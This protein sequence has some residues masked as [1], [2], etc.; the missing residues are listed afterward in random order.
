M[1]SRGTVV[2]RLQ[3]ATG[4]ARCFG[5]RAY[6]SVHLAV[7]EC[8]CVTVGAANL[9]IFCFDAKLSAGANV[10]DMTLLDR[11]RPD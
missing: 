7:S 8:V 2:V 6:D 4:L 9:V 3:C 10:L 1:T 11:Q 5:L